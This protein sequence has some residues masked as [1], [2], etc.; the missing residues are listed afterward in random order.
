MQKNCDFC[1]VLATLVT[2][3]QVTSQ[4]KLADFDLE[5]NPV[6]GVL[7]G[8]ADFANIENLR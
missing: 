3:A 5:I 2:R 7:K 6:L 8:H 1:F 4:W